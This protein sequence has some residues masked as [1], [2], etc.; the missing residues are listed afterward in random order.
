MVILFCK[1]DGYR[2]ISAFVVETDQ[3]GWKARVLER[4]MGI[5]ASTTAYVG[6]ENVKAPAE[7]LVGN[8]DDGF[9]IAMATLDG[10]R[11][12]VAAQSLGV[13]RRALDESVEYSRKRVAFGAPIAKLQAIQW[14]IADMATRLEAARLLTYQAAMLQDRGEPFSLIAAQAKLFAAETANFCVDKA[15][16]IHGGYGFIGEFSVIEKLYRDQRFLE[17]G[18]GTSEIQRMVIARMVLD[19]PKT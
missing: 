8:F 1:V 4:K 2:R 16:Q 11:I 6:L 15:M 10:A 14:M 5:R 3:P 19:S 12:N 17:I 13:A 7:N 9:K 18:E